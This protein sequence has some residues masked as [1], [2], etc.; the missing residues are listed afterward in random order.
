MSNP[1]LLCNLFARQQGL[2]PIGYAGTLDTIVAFELPLPWPRGV[3]ESSGRL[4]AGVHEAIDRFSREGAYRLRPLIIG[5]DPDYSVPGQ[6]RVLWLERPDGP[7]SEYRRTE[8]LVPDAFLG[9]LVAT[10]IRGRREAPGF[11]H[12][13]VPATGRDFLVCTH[14]AQ[15]TACGRFG[16]PL[17]RRLRAQ[18]HGS[19]NRAWRVTHFG[20]HVFAPTLLELPS[21]RMWAYLEHDDAAAL[22]NRSGRPGELRGNYRGWA[23]LEGPFLQ[24]LERELLT[25]QGW[26]WLDIPKTAEVLEQDAADD[27]QWAEVRLDAWRAS[28]PSS[29]HARVEISHSLPIRPRSDSPELKP[30]PQYRVTLHK[31]APVGQARLDAEAAA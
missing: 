30:Y 7:F 19:A 16:V 21:A 25:R 28:K 18:V 5:P 22:V 3:F 12:Y 17:Y 24:A 2:D 10:L 27:P 23:A 13:R 4:P 8:Y 26:E 20:G 31:P 29:F 1:P 14:G 6:R 9:E 11:D 15:D